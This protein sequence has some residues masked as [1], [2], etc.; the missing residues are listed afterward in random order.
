MDVARHKT[1]TELRRLSTHSLKAIVSSTGNSTLINSF[2]DKSAT[3]SNPPGRP[4][5]HACCK[6]SQYCALLL[7]AL[8]GRAW[9][10][11]G[12]VNHEHK[13]FETVNHMSS[14]LIASSNTLFRFRCVNAEHSKYLC[15]RI[16]LDTAKACS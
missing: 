16:S 7:L 14:H 8:P 4:I 1:L 3:F 5:P 9:S 15:A 12:P 6:S 2:L 10:E 13:P 11:D